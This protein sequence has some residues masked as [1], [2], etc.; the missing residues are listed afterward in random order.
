MI[1]NISFPF[2]ELFMTSMFKCFRKCIDKRCWTKKTS[3]KYKNEYISLY[4]SDIY[5]IEERYALIISIFWITVLFNCVIPVLNVIAALSIVLI[6]WIDKVLVFKFFKTPMNFDESLHRKFMKTLYIGL[7][8]HMVVSAF[9]LSEPNLIPKQSN[10]SN[11]DSFT[12]NNQRVNS[13]IQ[14]YYIIPYVALLVLMIVYGLF[15]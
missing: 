8:L 2:M 3:Q 10:F 11:F 9:F 13:L 15:K 14:T 7:I 1:F 12:S 6:F 5:P 4:S